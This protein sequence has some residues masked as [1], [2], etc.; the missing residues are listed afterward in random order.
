[1]AAA[2][3][4]PASG[5]GEPFSSWL[6]LLPI[7]IGLLFVVSSAYLAAVFLTDDAH[8]AGEEALSA[9]FR[10]RAI[11]AAGLAGGLAVVGILALRAD[12]RLIY[13]G[14]V[15]EG[16]PLVIASGLMGLG[17]LAK[18]GRPL[19]SYLMFDAPYCKELIDLGY[20]DAMTSRD[21]IL[22]LLGYDRLIAAT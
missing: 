18:E 4:V 11:L 12:A 20:R 6:Q 10:L 9:Y 2:G 14:L 15:D 8:R 1:M 16:L 22:H 21:Q 7:T 19:M 3:E 5:A 17:A 13:D